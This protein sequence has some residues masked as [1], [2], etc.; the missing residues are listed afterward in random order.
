MEGPSPAVVLDEPLV[1]DQVLVLGEDPEVEKVMRYLASIWIPCQDGMYVCW[2][3]DPGYDPGRSDPEPWTTASDLNVR[4]FE[5]REEARSWLPSLAKKYNGSHP[6]RTMVMTE[7]Q[8]EEWLVMRRI[9][10]A[11]FP[12]PRT[13]R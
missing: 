12:D 1:A 2:L 13:V 6:G 9:R 3:A 4:W 10:E 8:L 5:T 11:T 7:D